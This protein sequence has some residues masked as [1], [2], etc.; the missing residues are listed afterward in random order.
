MR[1]PSTFI[2][3]PN[4]SAPRRDLGPKLARWIS[5][6][7]QLAGISLLLSVLIGLPLGIVASRGGAVGQA[8]LAVVGMIQTIPSLALLALLVPVPFLGISATTAI[9]ALFLYGL[10]PIV[11]NT[12]TG[13]QDIPAR[14][15][16]FRN[17]ARP[18][19]GSASPQDLFAARLAHDSRRHQN[20][21]GD[22]YRHRH[23]GGADRR[24]R[25][26]R[27]DLERPESQR[28]CHDPRRSNP[29]RP[30]RAFGPGIVRSARSISDPAGLAAV[31]RCPERASARPVHALVVRP[32][33][34]G[35]GPESRR[36]CRGAASYRPDR[37]SPV[38]HVA[39]PSRARRN[40]TDKAA[41]VHASSSIR[42]S[43]CP[44][45]DGRTS[46]PL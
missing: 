10:L 36:A 27:T 11:R 18:R 20:Q 6:H 19:T 2:S 40:N 39:S 5:R 46:R 45:T 17:R 25:S 29:G 28:Q 31:D 9:V 8:I 34:I 7:L 16:R 14:A 32:M 24:R 4:E 37:S 3:T 1:H 15:A 35:S 22:Q 26:G 23:F 33:Q 43:R 30:P 21:R 41:R 44:S 42:P 13:L 12:A 38:P